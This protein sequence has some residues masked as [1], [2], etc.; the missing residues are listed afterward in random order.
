M[1]IKGLIRSD[2]GKTSLAI[3]IG[4]GLAT[5][6]R[7]ACK[8]KDCIRFVAPKDIRDTDKVYEH[9]SGCFSYAVQPATCE[10]G[11]R[12]VRFA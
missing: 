10:K 8:D 5:L 6:F 12:T 4:F 9:K 1:M 11:R 7:K 3:I 2:R